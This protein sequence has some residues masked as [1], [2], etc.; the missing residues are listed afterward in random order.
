MDISKASNFERY[1]FD[2]ADRDPAM[3][4]T[5]WNRVAQRRRVRS[6]RDAARPRGL[7]ESGFVSGRSTHADRIDTIRTVAQSYGVVVDPHTADGLKVALQHR[8]HGETAHLHRD[9][10]AGE[11]RDDDRRG[12]RTEPPRPA[13]YEGIESLPQRY[14]VLPADVDAVKAYIVKRPAEC[15]LRS[16]PA[17]A[18]SDMLSLLRDLGRNLV[19]GV[20]LVFGQPVTRL[21]FRIGVPQLL[22]LFVVSPLVDIG[23]DWVAARPAPN[24]R[25]KASSARVSSARC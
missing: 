15:S 3:V 7:R 19:S 1:V 12:A 6:R 23:V 5:L 10:A 13:S 14:G 16:L 25:R 20:R 11:V 18:T 22:V 21:A 2:L 24:S 8:E 4:R 9:R 17:R